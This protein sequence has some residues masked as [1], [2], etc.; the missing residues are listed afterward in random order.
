MRFEQFF[1]VLPLLIHMVVH[2]EVSL[3]QF[4]IDLFTNALNK[5]GAHQ[6]ARPTL[7]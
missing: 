2:T 4:T 5:N 7:F 1:H 3:F 6:Y